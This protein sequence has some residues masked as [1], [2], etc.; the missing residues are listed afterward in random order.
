[1]RHEEK[2]RSKGTQVAEGNAT[3]GREKWE[4]KVTSRA[5]SERRAP[6]CREREELMINC[7][8]EKEKSGLGREG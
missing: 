1:M 5:S 6:A 3:Q 2:S 7:F 8:A 4:G